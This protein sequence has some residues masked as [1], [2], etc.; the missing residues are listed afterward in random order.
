LK[1]HLL[2]SNPT[3]EVK[4]GFLSALGRYRDLCGPQLQWDEDRPQLDKKKL[5]M[6]PDVEQFLNK[7]AG[8][9]INC[10]SWPGAPSDSPDAADAW[11]RPQ[12]L[13][14][15]ADAFMCGVLRVVQGCA[16]PESAVRRLCLPALLEAGIPEGLLTSERGKAPPICALLKSAVRFCPSETLA[17]GLTFLELPGTGVNNAQ[18]KAHAREALSRRITHPVCMFHVE[19]D[20][21]ML[22]DIQRNY[23]THALVDILEGAARWVPVVVFLLLQPEHTAPL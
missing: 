11:Q 16:K 9:F 17:G 1:Q 19:A 21:G 4:E 12:G 23:L 5:Q 2:A 8:K 15:A 20:E 10:S 3:A 7:F 22:E 18:H 14:H 6:K 13:A